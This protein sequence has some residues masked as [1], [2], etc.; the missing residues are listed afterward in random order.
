MSKEKILQHVKNSESYLKNNLE[1]FNILEGDL[2]TSLKKALRDQISAGDS[3]E[4]A[5]NRAAPINILK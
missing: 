1:V 5:I 4:L 2:M 3:L